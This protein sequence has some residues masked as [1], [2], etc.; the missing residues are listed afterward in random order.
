MLLWFALDGTS[1]L[2]FSRPVKHREGRP[3]DGS[4]CT[5]EL[6]AAGSASQATAAAGRGSGGRQHGGWTQRRWQAGW[7]CVVAGR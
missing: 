6:A 3:S 7:R 5:R 4:G 2:E 1:F